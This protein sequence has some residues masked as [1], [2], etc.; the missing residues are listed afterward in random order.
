LST[1]STPFLPPPEVAPPSTLSA[2]ARLFIALARPFWRS[3]ERWAARLLLGAVILLT[4]AQTWIAVRLSFWGRD[5]YDT[6]QRGDYAFF[7][8][9]GVSMLGLIFCSITFWLAQDYLFSS[10]KIRWR[11]WMTDQFL[12]DWLGDRAH[13]LGQLGGHQGDNPDQR[14][15]EDIRAFVFTSLDL[16]KELFGALVGLLSFVFILWQLSASAPGAVIA[17]PRFPLPSL[18]EHLAWLTRPVDALWSGYVVFTGWITAIPG[19]LVWLCLGYSLIGSWLVGRVGRPI[20]GLRYEQQKLEADFRF[21]LVRLRENSESTALAAGE[22]AERRTLGLSFSRIVG[23]F[24][25]TLLR[26]LHLNAFKALY[27][28]LADLVPLLLSAPRF[29]SGAIS[30]GQLTQLTGAFGTVKSNFDFFI[31]NY[32]TIATWWAN[33]L[34]LDGF[35]RGIAHSRRLRESQRRVYA[36][37]SAASLEVADLVL[38][39]PDGRRLLAP[40]SFTMRPGDS[41]LVTGPSGSGK[42]TLLRALAGLWPYEKGRVLLP[43]PFDCLVMSQKPYLPVG[44][45][46][47][48]LS[49][50][51][52]P[53]TYAD[54]ELRRALQLCDLPAMAERLDEEAHWSQILSGGEQQRLAL[55]R[56]FLHRPAWLLLDEATAALD[57][58]AELAF[59]HRLRAALPDLTVLTIAHR[60]SLRNVH[61]RHFRIEHGPDGVPT[62]RED[63]SPPIPPT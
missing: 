19:H 55:G 52:E 50:P 29:F 13:Y 27:F 6:I 48:A 58:N 61:A 35:T 8:N 43:E 46:R 31:N 11:R 40:V 39:R 56:V 57:E 53:Q 34:R 60:S 20:I 12:R 62:L 41:V 5:F 63:R 45:L 18:P 59:Y 21:G 22:P 9:L 23:N 33:V 17:A 1:L 10:L 25:A 54:A 51:R 38:Y 42:S 30:L 16:G 4:L 7:V 24:N 47:A 28:R 44:S 37:A 32:E 14:I 49:Y 3:E 26:Q 2:K 36:P 15:A